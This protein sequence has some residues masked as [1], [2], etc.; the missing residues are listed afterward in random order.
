MFADHQGQLPHG[1]EALSPVTLQF[2]APTDSIVS[3]YSNPY[4][5]YATTTTRT[6]PHRLLC[7]SGLVLAVLPWLFHLS[8][9]YQGHSLQRT[10]DLATAEYAR[11]QR[12]F[13]T[14]KGTLKTAMA[15]VDVLKSSNDALL[16]Q[17]TA[18][19]DT[20]GVDVL[21]DTAYQTSAKLETGL[22][23][24]IGDL[25][26]EITRAS[27][28]N[29]KER[30]YLFH[31]NYVEMHILGMNGMDKHLVMEL[32]STTLVPHVVD[33]FLSLVDKRHYDGW[34]LLPRSLVDGAGG[35]GETLEAVNRGA[36]QQGK[37]LAAGLHIVASHN[38]DMHDQLALLQH[39]DEQLNVKYA[40]VFKDH[41]PYFYIN[42]SS[43]NDDN[44]TAAGNQNNFS[45][46]HNDVVIGTIVEGRE[47]IDFMA[48]YHIFLE[49]Q[50]MELRSVDPRAAAKTAAA[51]T[52]AA[53]TSTNADTNTKR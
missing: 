8:T 38:S 12:D 24:R 11:M 31:R 29:L 51:A 2:A 18:A 42:M 50:T 16:G 19:G 32:G 13:V 26:K 49:I 3:S 20:M 5:D 40:V 48:H 6:W 15:D 44:A 39:S 4:H 9:I 37:P 43:S 21:D 53:S 7:A 10:I 34:T 33:T 14:R 45:H 47:I 28:R 52:A 27:E 17:L 35:G 22:L 23:Q 25:E 36:D 1:E 30:D 46:N 41:G